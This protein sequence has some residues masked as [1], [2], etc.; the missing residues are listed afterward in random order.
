MSDSTGRGYAG[1]FGTST[2]SG[3]FNPQ[4]AVIEKAVANA[5][6][7]CYVQVKSVTNDDEI[8]A[9]G[10]VDAKPMVS[11]INGLG[12]PTE[13]STIFHLPY[14]RIQGGTNAIIIDPK[15]GDIGLA[16]IAD[17]DSSKV[18]ETKSESVPGSFRLHSLADGV[19]LGGMLNATPEQYVRFKNDGIEIV[20]ADKIT[21][22][23][24]IEI[25][26]TLTVGDATAVV[27]AKDGA[28]VAFGKVVGNSTKVKM[29]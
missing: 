10:F 2:L 18:N 25:T 28:V 14:I 26:G 15:V 16:I 29:V 9:V 4:W 19:Y 11:Q 13:H 5:R 1:F 12:E 24:D 8:S 17:R 27:A 23:K 20:A 21:L 6:T 7:A 3:N 22:T